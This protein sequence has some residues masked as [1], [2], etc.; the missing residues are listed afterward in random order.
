MPTFIDMFAGIGGIRSGLEQSGFKCNGWIE[1]DK[2]ARKSY[3]EIYQPTNEWTATDI[4]K[5]NAKDIP[6]SDLWSFGFPCQDISVAGKMKGIRNGTRSGLFY[7]VTKLIRETPKESKP[8]WLLIENVKN[9]LSI[10]KGQGFLSVLSELDEIGYDAEWNVFDSA[11][12]VPQ[13]RERVFLIGHLRGAGTRKIFHQDGESTATNKTIGTIKQIG[14]IANSKSFGGNPQ[15]GRVY[16]TDGISPTLNTM[17]GGGREPKIAIPCITPDRLNKRQ[18]GRRFKNNND[19]MFTLTA[20]DRHGIV[21]KG[22]LSNSGWGSFVSQNKSKLRIRK[23]TP[24]ETWRLQGFSDE[25]FN[26]AEKVNSNSQLYKQ[27]GNSVTVPVI[28]FIGDL[29]ME[30]IND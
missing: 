27:A 17:Q 29:I 22:N 18:N 6:K 8:K 2:F 4:T 1:I 23:L 13:H 5:V 9:L 24:L 7:T 30:S 11:N 12:F 26:R 14:N 20:T 10:D 21:V 28:K 15:V 19:N 3:E 25:S 16:G